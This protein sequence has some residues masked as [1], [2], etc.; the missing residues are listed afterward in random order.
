MDISTR[1]TSGLSSIA[2]SRASFPS[3][4]SPQTIHPGRDRR[5]EHRL[6]LISLLSSATRIRRDESALVIASPVRRSYGQLDITSV[7]QI[8]GGVKNVKVPQI[9]VNARYCVYCAPGSGSNLTDLSF[10]TENDASLLRVRL[11][12]MFDQRERSWALWLVIVWWNRW[13]FEF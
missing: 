3:V 1:I 11:H 5:T 9:I 4:A 7:V 12:P 13:P 6:P 8:V 10:Q 2:F